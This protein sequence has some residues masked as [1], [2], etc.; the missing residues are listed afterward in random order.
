MEMVIAHH[1]YYTHFEP[2]DSTLV[3]KVSEP[4]HQGGKKH[5]KIRL[6]HQRSEPSS[7]PQQWVIESVQ[8]VCSPDCL[9]VI[10]AA[11]FILINCTSLFLGCK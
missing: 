1:D 9:S 5:Q 6:P 3:N 8:I 10:A 2:F 7:N 11:N 4:E